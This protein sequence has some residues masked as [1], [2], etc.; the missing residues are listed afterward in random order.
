MLREPE[1]H[2]TLGNIAD[3]LRQH[4]WTWKGCGALCGLIGGI[5]ASAIGSVFTAIAWITGDHW[6]GFP[7]QRAGTILLFLTVPLLMFGAHCLDLME[8][9]PKR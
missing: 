1:T 5:V 4:G 8:R 9:Q 6:A 3:A 7:V 2:L